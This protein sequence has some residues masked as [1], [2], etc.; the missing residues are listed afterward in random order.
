MKSIS[1]PQS[2]ESKTPF[3]MHPL[4]LALRHLLDKVTHGSLSMRLPSGETL[5]AQ[6]EPG[7]DATL[8]VKEWRALRRMILQGD[9][10]LADGFIA[11][12][13]TT[14]DLVSLLR[15]GALNT[16]VLEG[17][18]GNFA[19][20]LFNRLRHRLRGN[21]RRGSRRNIISHYD[22]GNDFFAEW[23]DESMLYSSALYGPG[24]DTLEDAQQN[25]LT[26]IS[27]F[28]NIRGGEDVLEIGFGWGALAH[29]LAQSGAASVTG[30]TL[31]PAQ[32][33]FAQQR[34]AG[35][36]VELRLQ[37]YRDVT[38]QFDCVVSIEMIEAVGEAYWPQYFGKIAEVL[39]PG[40]C[41]LIQA[42]TIDETRYEN[43]R[44]TPD[45]IQ[46]HIFP[47]GFL[48]TKS[49]IAEQAL[50]AG[51]T[52]EKTETFGLSYARTLA[53][54]RVRFEARWPQIEA[55]G[56]DEQFRRLWDYYL[57][58][59]EAGFTEGATDVGFYLLR[60]SGA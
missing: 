29:H 22:L 41:A 25:R 42:I 49:I 34:C 13:W 1:L 5:E 14:S 9:I 60:K 47:G 39:R 30:L 45:F 23:L 12:E 8:V 28:M 16:P 54:W 7:P 59:C 15:F 53:D 40:G 57:C 10:G 3:F 58:Y 35:A 6:G 11:G 2:D 55:Q 18:Y 38:G 48:P 31:S 26:R 51:L 44:E 17:L 27:D 20:R 50:A 4:A 36:P 32:L 52:L 19:H 46:R 56:F 24:V 33:A 21:S 43:Y 37:D